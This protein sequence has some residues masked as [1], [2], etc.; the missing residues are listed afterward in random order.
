VK[1]ER[2]AGATPDPSAI[3]WL[4]LRASSHQGKGRMEKIA[5]V[6]RVQTHGGL[7]PSGG[8]DSAHLG[9]MQRVPY[10]ATYCFLASQP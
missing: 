10:T 8:C 7:A 2:I 3:P 5:W 1:G 6:Q 4:V 9:A